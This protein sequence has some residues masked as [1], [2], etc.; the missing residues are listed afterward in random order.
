MYHHEYANTMVVPDSWQPKRGLLNFVIDGQWGSTG[1]GKLAHLLG[2]YADAVVCDYMPNAGHTVVHD[3]KQYVFR[4]LPVACLHPDVKLV[5]L[6]PGSVINSDLFAR[7]INWVPP[8]TQV[9]VDQNAMYVT[10]ADA[11]WEREYQAGMGST[12][13]GCGRALQRKIKRDRSVSLV[14]NSCGSASKYVGCVFEAIRDRMMHGDVVLAETAQGFGL[15]LNHGMYPHVTSRDVT[16][17]S[18]L[19]RMGGFPH[20]DIGHVYGIIRTF[21]IRV[22][23]PSGP[24]WHDQEEITWDDVPVAPAEPERTTVTNKI[25]RVFT[26][27]Q[28]QLCH[29]IH[30]V[31]PSHLFVNFANYLAPD[32]VVPWLKNNVVPNVRREMNH[33]IG[34]GVG[35]QSQENEW[36][37]FV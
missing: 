17:T 7:E 15:S 2:Q 29:F 5:C 32:Q 33:T 24:C 35:A 30:H 34:L 22:G 23:G 3:G 10:D 36:W 27:S 12:C 8:D 26:F 1:K 28:T 21:P 25:R 9:I 6:G 31:N 4:Q 18:A 14:G 20:T 13:K 19:D 11:E 16:V 37:S